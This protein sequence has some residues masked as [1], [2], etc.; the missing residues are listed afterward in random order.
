MP[1]L[2]CSSVGKLLCPS[3]GVQASVC[4]VPAEPRL[5]LAHCPP[6]P[7][8]PVTFLAPRPCPGAG[9]AAGKWAKHQAHPGLPARA[10]L[11]LRTPHS[12]QA[13]HEPRERSGG[14][15]GWD[16]VLRA[17]T[18]PSRPGA[19]T[20]LVSWCEG[21]GPEDSGRG[22]RAGAGPGGLGAGG[23]WGSPPPATLCCPGLPPPYC[24]WG[25]HLCSLRIVLAL[26]SFLL[27]H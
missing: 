27:L 3:V 21:W 11:G 7:A 12:H 18:P 4:S 19:S 6:L 8:G 5:S 15:Q 14:A 9:Q 23:L 24:P 22:R 17:A 20:H 16:P 1:N 10:A 25:R 13:G 26:V 2:V